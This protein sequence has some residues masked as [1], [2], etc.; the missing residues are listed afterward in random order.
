[1]LAVYESNCATLRVLSIREQ[2]EEY[3]RQVEVR[4]A[5][6]AEVI[7]IGLVDSDLTMTQTRQGN[8]TLLIAQGESIP[9]PVLQIGNTD[10]RLKFP[11]GPADFINAWCRADAP[12]CFGRGPHF[13]QDREIRRHRITRTKVLGG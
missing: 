12:L 5:Q 4:I 8:L 13:A 2:P 1:M 10:S 3:Q 7:S 11:L 6:R 9:G